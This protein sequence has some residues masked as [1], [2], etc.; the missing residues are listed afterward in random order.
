M[1]ACIMQRLWSG[2]DE[3]YAVDMVAV[4]RVRVLQGSVVECAA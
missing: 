3:G 2:R 4:V 1:S